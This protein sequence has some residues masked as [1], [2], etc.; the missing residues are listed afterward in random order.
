VEIQDE[1]YSIQ[2]SIQLLKPELILAAGIILLIVSGFFKPKNENI[3]LIIAT[4]FFATTLTCLTID[5]P[6]G[7]DLFGGMIRKEGFS[8][9]LKI[10]LNVSAL[11]TCLMALNK[12][13]LTKYRN[14]F[15]SLLMAV[16]LGGHFFLMSNNLLM[17][18]L[19]MELVSIGSYVLAAFAFDKPASE[20]SLKYFLF[21]S[22]ASATMLYGFSLLYGQTGTLDFTSEQFAIA[23][24]QKNNRLILV[25]GVMSLGG[26]LFKIAAA[27]MHQW[28]PDVYQAAPFPV[29]AF[30]STVPKLAG[31][32]ALTK[33]VMSVNGSGPGTF[34]WQVIIAFVAVLSITVG[35]FA[36][37][38]QKNTKR[39]MAYSS[40]AQSGFM[41][42][43]I[44]AFLPQGLHFMLFYAA[45]YVVTNFAVFIY[46]GFFEEKGIISVRDFSGYGKVY[47]V[48]MV[49]L[50]TGLISL[51]GLPPTSGFTA[52]LFI[53]SSAWES[54]QLSGKPILLWL[55][56]LGLLNTAVS[57][58][59]YL[60]IPYYGFLKEKP[61]EIAQ[62]VTGALAVKRQNFMTI[63][64][65]LPLILVLLILVLFLAPGLLMGWIN[66][67]NFVF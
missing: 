15:A 29:I 59:Y 55:L 35:N 52:K 20:G 61:V 54:Y 4:I 44:A 31:L 39:L 41:A 16:V 1:L 65:L 22:V 3:S 26:F 58:F 32:G 30:L 66:K 62:P 42:I 50:L 64:N 24:F 21:G 67:V 2:N 17:T 9:F 23:L 38:A 11:L 14:E 63:E 19:S 34:D 49:C 33:F 43:G 57:L 13:R 28:A 25:A 12:N 8:G 10:L 47:W 7:T 5:D 36:A 27:P 6:A 37:L 18:F 53:F 40:I 48:Q 56:I 46:L 60:K 45:I 51:T